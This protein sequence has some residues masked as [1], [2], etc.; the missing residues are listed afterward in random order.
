MPLH[1]TLGQ[2][3]TRIRIL[4]HKAQERSKHLQQLQQTL[5]EQ[6]KEHLLARKLQEESQAT[7]ERELERIK[8][9]RALDLQLHEHGKTGQQLNQ[10]ISH[11]HK[12]VTSGKE[13]QQKLSQQLAGLRQGLKKLRRFQA[14]HA[15]DALLVEQFAGL[16]QQLLHLGQKAGERQQLRQVATQAKQQL[17]QL[18]DR[19]QQLDQNVEQRLQALSLH[20]QEQQQL[21][22]QRAELLDAH[23]VGEL[24][25][26]L[27][28]QEGRQQQLE[29]AEEWAVQLHASRESVLRLQG[30]G[31]AILEQQQRVQE[32]LQPLEK[33][34]MLGQQ[35]VEQ[36][37]KNQQLSLRIRSYEEERSR[38]EEGVP[39][40]LCGALDHPWRL[41]HPQTDGQEGEL[42][43]ARTELEQSRMEMSRLRET[44][45]VLARDLEHNRQ[46][47]TEQ[48]QQIEALSQ[49]LAALLDSYQLG[50]LATC[51]SALAAALDK[52]LQQ[53]VSLR[54]RLTAHDQL[55][56]RLEAL[57]EKI[58]QA[59]A[60]HQ[61]DIQQ[62]QANRQALATKE[63]ERKTLTTR[64]EETE[65]WLNKTRQE[66]QPQ[67]AAF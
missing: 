41:E 26:E 46:R 5:Q 33:Q 58:E 27:S 10:K 22:Q 31:K 45:A 52:T 15:V 44:L 59:S 56:S 60:L 14:E 25:Q 1:S 48:Q 67:T 9:V 11:L 4:E 20:K 39:C 2:L 64:V 42:V 29:R 28:N 34:L 17:V 36:C 7:R 50:P 53:T 18:D 35:L 37:E 32:Q 54:T 6:H 63:I 51:T 47:Q 16:Q 30:L 66:L 62:A 3:Q 57:N 65:A 49:Q 55:E 61:Q 40:P 13:E 12:A 8:K 24:R 43:R 21:L 19:Q 23:T 38:L